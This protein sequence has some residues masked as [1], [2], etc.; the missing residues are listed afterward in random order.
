MD[1]DLARERFETALADHTPDFGRFFLVRLLDLRISY[2][3][4]ERTCRVD[5][6]ANE[7]LDNPQG[8]L[9]GGIMA[10]VLDISMGHLCHRHL[11]TAVT[12]EMKTAYLRPVRGRCW[13]RGRFVKPGRRIVHLESHLHDEDGRLAAHATSTWHRVEAAPQHP[14]E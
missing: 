14:K 11:S 4:A 10:T 12:L 5:M 8:S 2:D 6:P 13:A 1:P 9:H 7:L 3:D